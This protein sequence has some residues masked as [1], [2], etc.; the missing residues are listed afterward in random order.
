MKVIVSE[1]RVR[2]GFREKEAYTQTYF[3]NSKILSS[4]TSYIKD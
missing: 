2:K 4:I 3:R 1:K